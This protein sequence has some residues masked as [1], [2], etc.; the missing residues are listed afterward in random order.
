MRYLILSLLFMT[1]KSFADTNDI[2][3]SMMQPSHTIWIIIAIVVA[4]ICVLILNKEGK[5]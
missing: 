4:F 3:E 5:G 1:S 2:V